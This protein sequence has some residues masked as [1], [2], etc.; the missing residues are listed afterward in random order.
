MVLAP[1]ARRVCVRTCVPTLRT[2]AY[3]PLHPAAG[4]SRTLLTLRIFMPSITGVLHTKNDGL[5]VGRCLETLYPCDDIVVVD[6]G[7]SD[8]TVQ[9]AR[10]YGASVLKAKNG[11]SIDQYL[12]SIQGWVLC[13]DPSESLTES[14]AAS[15]FEWK[16]GD[17]ARGAFSVFLREETPTG[18][19]E[20]PA[21]QT[22]LV[23]RSWERWDGR[24]PTHEPAAVALQGELLRF[25][26]P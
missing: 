2:Q 23:P 21:A 24:F 12:R 26:F 11:A 25:V 19:V 20:N 14:L 9:V 10:T 22:R 8:A 18:W 13:L 1:T 16:T 6:H 5:R 7:S 17:A 15:L 4:A 3:V